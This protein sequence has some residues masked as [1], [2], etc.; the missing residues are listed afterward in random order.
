[1]KIK[2]LLLLSFL[3]IVLLSACDVIEAV[4]PRPDIAPTL[5]AIRTQVMETVMAE[6]AERA[7]A[8]PP[9]IPT[10]L[11][12]ATQPPLPTPLPTLEPTPT[13]TA[14]P[15]TPTAIPTI[16][17]TVVVRKP[18]ITIL[19]V[20]ENRAVTL[21]AMDFPRDSIFD[22]RVGP[23]QNF[24][25]HDVVIGRVNTGS[26]DPFKFTV[27]LPIE[28]RNVDQVTV[29]LD[30]ILGQFAFTSFRN[31]DLGKVI[32]DPI[33]VISTGCE[34]SVSPG[35]SRTFS[36][37]E[38]FDAVWTVR[39][40]SSRTWDE[41]AVDYLFLSGIEMQ[42]FEK[43]FDLPSSVKSGERIK[44]IVDMIAPDRVGNFA[45]HWALVQDSAIVCHLPLIVNVK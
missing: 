14:I 19:A 16:T 23:F 22:I 5:D 40:T 8:T 17:P 6:L 43:L 13:P 11:P 30:G 28:V 39:N 29:R 1:M 26:G 33:P 12:T 24:F 37:N 7:T 18:T 35:A 38:D 3:V 32:Y 20:E 2:L 25:D 9:V 10:P 31:T 15:P 42:K 44:I 21:L 41:S 27:I 34:V 36:R 4:Q 45:T